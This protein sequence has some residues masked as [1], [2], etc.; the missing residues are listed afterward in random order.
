MTHFS[1]TPAVVCSDDTIRFGSLEFPVVSLVGM[2]VPPVFE[3]F[4]AFRFGSLDFATDRLGVLHLREKAH[5]PAPVEGAPSIDFGTRDID[6]TASALLFEQTLCSNPV[7]SNTRIITYSSFTIPNRA[8]G[9]TVSSTPQT[10]HDRFP[11]GLASSVDTYAWGIRRVLVPFPLTSK[12][13][14]M[15][16]Y[17]PAASHE[18]LDGEGVSNDSNVGD[19]APRHHPSQE[20]AM[21]DAP[22]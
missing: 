4:Q 18:P 10:P 15:V 5:I 6:G 2:R 14:G 11:Y 3:P 7:V 16:G 20:C 12:F 21:A 8:P 9:E 13:I 22:G 19:E 17:S 1:A